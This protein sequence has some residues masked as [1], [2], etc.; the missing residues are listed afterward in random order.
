MA[1]ILPVVVLVVVAYFYYRP[2]SSWLHTRSAL[3]NRQAQVAALERQKSQLERAVT[4]AMSLQSLTRR[5][6]RIGLVQQGEQL[7]IVKGIPAWRR[8]HRHVKG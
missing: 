5:A 4:R 7:F 1:R 3:A 8:A 6:R 2:L